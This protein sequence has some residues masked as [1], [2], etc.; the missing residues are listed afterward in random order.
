MAGKSHTKKPDEVRLAIRA[1]NLAEARAMHLFRIE[2]ARL[3]MLERREAHFADIRRRRREA[4][5]NLMLARELNEAAAAAQPGSPSWAALAT[6]LAVLAVIGVAGVVVYLMLRKKSDN[7]LQ[8]GA[9]DP[10]LLPA[11]SAP[12]PQVFVIN[13]G[14]GQAVPTSGLTPTVSSPGQT[15]TA[16]DRIEALLAARSARATRT[17]AV[18]KTMRLP[19]LGDKRAQAQ[20]VRVATSLQNPYEVTVRVVAPP[21]ALAAL[22]FSQT[23]L[24]DQPLIAPGLSTVPTGDVVII[25]AGGFQKIRM[26]PRQALFGRGNMSPDHP[27]GAV[28]ISVS[29]TDDFDAY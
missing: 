29:A 1:Q 13:A 3:A 8:L 10:Q 17:P 4:A 16:I 14:T 9:Y 15:G 18:M 23:E 21:G 7:S 2:E 25:P 5:E 27:T 24:E 26:N 22:S 12:Q 28:L 6:G 19:W 11:A 20:A